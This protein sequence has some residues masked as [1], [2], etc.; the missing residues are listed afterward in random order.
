MSRASARSAQNFRVHRDRMYGRVLQIFS[1]RVYPHIP[2]PYACPELNY[3]LSRFLQEPP[4]LHLLPIELSLSVLSYLPL[5]TLCSLLT[6]SHQW[7]DLFSTHQPTI[8]RNAAIFHGYIQPGTMLLDDALTV[9]EGSPWE[10]ATN[11]KDFCES[12]ILWCP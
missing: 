4:M 5:P 10:G 3:Q 6:L 11:W 2:R 1:F 9:Y 12:S 7:F 8:F